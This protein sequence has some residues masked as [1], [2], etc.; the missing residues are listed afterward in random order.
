MFA[1]SDGLGEPIMFR[2]LVISVAHEL[3]VGQRARE[4]TEVAS[5][6]AGATAGAAGGMWS[7]RW[8]WRVMT[9][10]ELLKQ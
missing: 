9:D 3:C 1:I 4:K 8:T 5:P 6:A 7:G 2:F 10:L